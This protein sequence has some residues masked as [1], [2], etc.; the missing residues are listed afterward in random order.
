M[1]ID[2]LDR[3]ISDVIAVTETLM[4]A[5]SADLA[6]L[7]PSATTVEKRHQSIGTDAKNKAK[8]MKRPMSHGVHRA[9]C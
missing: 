8:E 1:S 2:L 4:K 3:L 9:V 7:Q 5:E 6:A